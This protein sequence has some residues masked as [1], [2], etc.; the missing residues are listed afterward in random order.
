MLTLKFS[1]RIFKVGDGD[2]W[3]RMGCFDM[4]AEKAGESSKV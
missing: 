4:E 2:V 1:H 3:C